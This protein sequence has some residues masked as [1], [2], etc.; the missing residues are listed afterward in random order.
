MQICFIAHSFLYSLRNS[1]LFEDLSKYAAA[2]YGW[3]IERIS[4]VKV[5]DLINLNFFAYAE[6]YSTDTRYT[7]LNL[8]L[9]SGYKPPVDVIHYA[10]IMSNGDL[11][12]AQACPIT[13]SADNK[14]DVTTPSQKTSGYLSGNLVWRTRG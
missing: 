3:K 12:G 7:V 2:N 4:F 11:T 6:N 14:V 5:G 8:T 13:V 1:A 10:A 9:P